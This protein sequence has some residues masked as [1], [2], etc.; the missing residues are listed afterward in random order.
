MKN[1]N[2][3]S[4]YTINDVIAEMIDSVINEAVT[5]FLKQKPIKKAPLA[6]DP[7][8]FYSNN[9]LN[10]FFTQFN[11]KRNPNNPN[12]QLRVEKVFDDNGS[13]LCYKV[14]R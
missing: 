14:Y 7:R 6:D 8:Y 3:N 9:E 12:H 13:M 4:T 1:I 2:N 11:K 10:R 5:H